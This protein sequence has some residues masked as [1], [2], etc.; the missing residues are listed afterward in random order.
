M[1]ITE[2]N[3]E[4]IKKFVGYCS[5]KLKINSKEINIVLSDVGQTE[6]TAGHFNP[7]TKKINVT[8]KN[9]AIADCLRTISHEMTHFKQ[10]E[11]GVDFPVDD[12]GLQPYEDE[13][14]VMSGRLVRFFGRENRVIYSDIG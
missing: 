10:L 12:E 5:E 11:D 7:N 13:A 14:N 9:R 3:I 1:K 4:L 8:V 2:E 6:P